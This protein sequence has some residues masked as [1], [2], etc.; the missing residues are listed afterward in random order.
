MIN[1]FLLCALA[2]GKQNLVDV[3]TELGD[4]DEVDALAGMALREG[5]VSKAAMRKLKEGVQISPGSDRLQAAFG[6]ASLHVKGADKTAI[7]HMRTALALNPG[8]P[9]LHQRLGVKLALEGDTWGRNEAFAL[10]K[11]ALLLNPLDHESYRQV[12]RLHAQLDGKDRMGKPLV[13]SSAERWAT[14]VGGEEDVVTVEWRKALKAKPD[15]W[16]VHRDMALRLVHSSS[17]KRRKAALKHAEVAVE[18]APTVAASYYTLAAA[19]LRQKAPFAAGHLSLENASVVPAKPRAAAIKALRRAVLME[20]S[21]RQ[22]HADEYYQLGLL[23]LTARSDK[24][25]TYTD[26]LN[27]FVSARFI[28]PKDE[29]IEMAER[30]CR[31]HVQR[32]TDEQRRKAA[33]DNDDDD[34]DDN[35]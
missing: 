13:S 30:N 1:M 33:D 31:Q 27:F 18:L 6:L 23:L 22:T 9:G 29:N 10:F 4:D 5:K 16:S 28:R 35:N 12:G 25:K 34:D 15:S 2:R 32:S 3:P 7:R 17:A 21:Q 14:E 26:A 11:T 24:E 20:Q 8:F 19:T